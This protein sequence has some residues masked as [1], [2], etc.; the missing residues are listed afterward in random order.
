MTLF[1]AGCGDDVKVS[2]GGGGTGTAAGQG[3]SG[4]SGGGTTEPGGMSDKIDVLFMIDNSR[5]MA[6]KQQI[7][8]LGIPDLL[9]SLPI[10][11]ATTPKAWSR[12]SSPRRVWRRARTGPRAGLRHSTQHVGVITS[13]LGGH[14]ADVCTST[15]TPSE[16]DRGHLISRSGTGVNDPPIGTYQNL[17]YLAWDPGGAQNPPGTS[18][19]GE[20]NTNL[21]AMVN[22]AGQ[23]GCGFEA[24]LES[25][26]R[27]LVDPDPHASIR[28]EQDVAVLE[29][30]D[31][32]LLQQRATSCAPIRWCS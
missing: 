20:L 31:D 6:D 30:T 25:W 13:S 12:R 21:A 24:S 9:N 5:S 27:F 32:V 19:F 11:C 23:V 17:G 7:L 22:G 2:T 3:G 14:G 8:S 16:D 18:D 29:G 1:A 15:A 4:G 28:L 26:Y 10:R